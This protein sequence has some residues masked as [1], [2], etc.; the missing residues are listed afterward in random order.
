M[1]GLLLDTTPKSKDIPVNIKN[2][3][4]IDM[5]NEEIE[6]KV[7]QDLMQ[8][9]LH[10]IPEDKEKTFLMGKILDLPSDIEKKENIKSSFSD[11]Q[12]FT[13]HQIDS[14]SME[15]LV[16]IASFLKNNPGEP[17]DFPT[18]SQALKI[19]LLDVKVQN[20]FKSA[21]NIQ[22]LLQIA[23]KNG[24]KVKNFEFFKEERSL[25]PSTK[26]SIQK[27]NSAEIFKFIE[28]D[29]NILSDKN[30]NT[31]S[32][33]NHTSSKKA[34]LEHNVLTKLLSSK[35]T[36]TNIQIKENNSF[37]MQKQ[38]K[39]KS[40]HLNV[41]KVFNEAKIQ[42]T[43]SIDDK[44]IKISNETSSFTTQKIRPIQKD[45]PQNNQK[46]V[47]EKNTQKSITNIK[48][49]AQSQKTLSPSIE[50]SQNNEIKSL[51]KTHEKAIQSINSV[52]TAS[53]QSQATI[54]TKINEPVFNIK[55][56]TPKIITK[57]HIQKETNAVS[58]KQP[59]IIPPQQN[60]FKESTLTLQKEH[61]STK[62][63]TEKETSANLSKTKIDN[64]FSK[65]AENETTSSLEKSTVSHETNKPDTIQPKHTT[66]THD[67]QK[68]FHNFA[69][70]FKEKVESYKPPLM[71][72][73]M[74]LSPKNLGDVDVTL[75]NRGNNLHVNINSTPNTIAIFTQNQTEFKNA[76][77]NMGFTGLQMN[78]GE[79]KEQDRGQQGYKSGKT[80]KNLP[81]DEEQ[82]L[83]SFEIIVPRYI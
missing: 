49:T 41:K 24:I 68:T 31:T 12:L 36:S 45:T 32:K 5:E 18:D 37:T 47:I 63:E 7:F 2:I 50:P 58:T 43:S 26:Q 42:T 27:L 34:S 77:V 69:Q 4:D 38:S 20:D 8:D 3:S 25:T 33:R 79:S 54:E 9:L 44:S 65:V 16:S 72:I 82:E 57:P 81:T 29:K 55:Q 48:V 83:N 14:V 64:N 78:F 22:D 1:N 51:P 52:L 62:T 13:D 46:A 35:Q 21:K 56:H 67:T 66:K 39:D 75:I 23:E 73:K 17:L 11:K 19:S 10:D 60:S 53:A 61:M 71:K 80:T 28:Q 59:E 70:E 76:L 6:G 74:Q 30:I 40:N 15:N